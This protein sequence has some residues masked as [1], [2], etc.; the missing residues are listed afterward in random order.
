MILTGDPDQPQQRLR[1]TN[2]PSPC[3]ASELPRG[4]KDPIEIPSPPSSLPDNLLVL[5]AT[6]AIF[7]LGSCQRV[8]ICTTFI[9]DPSSI[10]VFV[11]FKHATQCIRMIETFFRL[12]CSNILCLQSFFVLRDIQTF[13]GIAKKDKYLRPSLF[14]WMKMRMAVMVSLIK[15]R[16]M[17]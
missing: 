13:P 2:V 6:A 7:I 16:G 15:W 10:F 5:C 17:K 3:G 9:L 4:T 12:R 8:S 1:M 14:A 11:K